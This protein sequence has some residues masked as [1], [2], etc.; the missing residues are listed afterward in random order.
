MKAVQGMDQESSIGSV[1]GVGCSYDLTRLAGK[2][3]VRLASA[4]GRNR[5]IMSISK[6]FSVQIL[7]LQRDAFVHDTLSFLT[8]IDSVLK[9]AFRRS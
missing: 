9:C 7:P 3:R 5:H 2:A 6:L 4:I 1:C 8:F